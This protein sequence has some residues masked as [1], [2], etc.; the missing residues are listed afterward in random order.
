VLTSGSA[1]PLLGAGTNDIQ[2]LLFG[3]PI[4]VNRFVPPYSGLLI[5]RNAVVSAT[6]PVMVAT[7]EHTY[8]SSDSIALRATWRIGWNVVRPSGIGKFNMT[9]LGS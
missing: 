3:L 9:V 8:F 1:Q 6:A 7:S 4:I 5:D 2:Q